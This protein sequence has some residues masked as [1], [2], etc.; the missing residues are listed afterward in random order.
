[1]NKKKDN[2]Q[3]SIHGIFVG[4]SLDQ[5]LCYKVFISN[6]P[7]WEDSS[8]DIGP[9]DDGALTRESD[10]EDVGVVSVVGWVAFE[11]VTRA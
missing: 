1:M 10:V 4:Y 7:P 11:Y 3:R 5:S 2:Q 9:S 8:D 6:I